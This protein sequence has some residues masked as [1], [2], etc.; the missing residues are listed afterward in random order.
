MVCLQPGCNTIEFTFFSLNVY[1]YVCY[2]TLYSYQH[3]ASTLHNL[4][5][6]HFDLHYNPTVHMP[7]THVILQQNTTPSHGAPGLPCKQ[8]S[9]VCVNES[10]VLCLESYI[11]HPSFTLVI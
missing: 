5:T 3:Y 9:T 7:N 1:F 10:V 2:S 11:I 8:T 6:Q 4:A